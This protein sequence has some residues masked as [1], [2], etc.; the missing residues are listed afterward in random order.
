MAHRRC[1]LFLLRLLVLFFGIDL[2]ASEKADFRWFVSHFEGRENVQE[3]LLPEGSEIYLVSHEPVVSGE[4]NTRYRLFGRVV[5]GSL[6]G[7]NVWLPYETDYPVMKLFSHDLDGDKLAF[8]TDK[9]QLAYHAHVVRDL[10]VFED[11]KKFEQEKLR[12]ARKGKKWDQEYFTSLRKYIPI[13][14]QQVTLKA[15]DFKNACPDKPQR[16]NGQECFNQGRAFDLPDHIMTYIENAALEAELIYGRMI[17]PA[18]VASIIHAETHFN[19]FRENRY[20]K[21]LCLQKKQ[22]SRYMWGKGLA[23]LGKTTAANFGIDWN[24]K[25]KKPRTCRRNPRARACFRSLEKICSQF[26]SD[27]SGS[28]NGNKNLPSPFCPK[29]AIRAVAYKLAAAIPRN[30]IVWVRTPEKTVRKVNIVPYLFQN[31]TTGNRVLA[32]AYNRRGAR[33]YNSFV[34]HYEQTGRF[35]TEF[36]EAWAA[37]RREGRT[38]SS[39]IGYSILN[40]EFIN[41]CY[42]WNIA[43]ICGEVPEA[44]LLYQYRK[45]FLERNHAGGKK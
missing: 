32:A 13:T 11:N 43:G 2:M 42:V 7:R 6:E 38:P 28:D 9:L 44:S 4:S 15:S 31:V 26:D 45:K 19:T 33:V 37:T 23:Q 1:F 20:E 35:P 40:K 5:S 34:E 39:E 3:L 25:I 16:K 17:E 8:P 41:R 24:R 18:L 10:P 30:Q 27:T 12:H 14:N 22:C 36:G 21:D 29:M